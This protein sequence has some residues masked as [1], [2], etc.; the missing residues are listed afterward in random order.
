MSSDRE[1][2]SRHGTRRRSW[3]MLPP[4]SPVGARH[5]S[6]RARGAGSV[7]RRAL[8]RGGLLRLTTALSVAPGVSRSAR[9]VR[10]V[11]RLK[12]GIA[13]ADPPTLPVVAGGRGREDA[14][15]DDEAD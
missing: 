11:V 2:P 1:S 5:P 6:C 10:L 15:Q 8:P 13:P 7:S 3:R 12:G 4:R 14:E 9:V